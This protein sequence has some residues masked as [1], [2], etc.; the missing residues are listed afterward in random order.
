MKTLRTGAK[1]KLT[2]KEPDEASDSILYDEE[3]QKESPSKKRIRIVLLL[4]ANK[5]TEKYNNEIFPLEILTFIFS[6]LDPIPNLLI[7][8]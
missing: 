5:P 7:T 1:R 6:F 2:F 3:T 8:R 4:N